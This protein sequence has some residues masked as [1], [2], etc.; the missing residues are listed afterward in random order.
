MASKTQDVHRTVIAILDSGE[1]SDFEDIFLLHNWQ[2]VRSYTLNKP[3]EVPGME[4][5]WTSLVSIQ[6]SVNHG[7]DLKRTIYLDSCKLLAF[8]KNW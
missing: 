6:T 7:F 3:K 4:N 5:G 2:D 8:Q 1:D